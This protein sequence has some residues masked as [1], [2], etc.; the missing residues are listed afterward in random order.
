MEDGEE[1][2]VDD[3]IEY[4]DIYEEGGGHGGCFVESDYLND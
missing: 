1:D 2:L 4:E 3:S